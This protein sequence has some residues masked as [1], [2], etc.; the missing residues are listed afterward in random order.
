MK[1]SKTLL[2][3]GLAAVSLGIGTA[4]ANDGGGA[5][6]DYWA[7]QYRIQAARQAAGNPAAPQTA[8]QFGS[9]D[10]SRAPVHIDSN[11]TDG[12]L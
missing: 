6:Q 3:A 2:L 1:T 7:Q 9:S 10:F 8:P 12:G 5:T 4:M 11:M